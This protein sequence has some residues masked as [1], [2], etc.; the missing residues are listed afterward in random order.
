MGVLREPEKDI[1][2]HSLGLDRSTESYRNYFCAETAGC[3]ADQSTIDSLVQLGFMRAA[4][5]INNGRD[6]IYVVTEAG[7]QALNKKV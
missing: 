4:R 7:R 1:I 3:H 2:R 5:T 6:T